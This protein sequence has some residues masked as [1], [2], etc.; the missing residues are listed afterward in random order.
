MYVVISPGYRDAWVQVVE[1][2]GPQSDLLV[3][4]AVSGLNLQLH[5]LLLHPLKRF[6]LGLHGSALPKESTLKQ[7]TI[8]YECTM[9]DGGAKFSWAP[10]KQIF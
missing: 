6:L 5:Q 4:L 7:H 8:T 2:G 3:L 1:L 9:S 10:F